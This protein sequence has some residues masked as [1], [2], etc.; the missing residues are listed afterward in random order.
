MIN[1]YCNKNRVVGG[2]C[3]TY[4]AQATMH[5]IHHAMQH[6]P[7]DHQYSTVQHP[8]V[9]HH[10]TIHHYPYVGYTHQSIYP[11]SECSFLLD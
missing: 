4:G 1:M 9:Q 10:Q 6:M 2:V 5:A 3:A 7:Q 8:V 11:M